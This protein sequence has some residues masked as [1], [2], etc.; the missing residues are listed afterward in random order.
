MHE[1]HAQFLKSAAFWQH[2]VELVGLRAA[3]ALASTL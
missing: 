1:L 3:I 2:I